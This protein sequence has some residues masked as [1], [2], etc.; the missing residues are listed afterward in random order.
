MSMLVWVG[1]YIEIET[2]AKG[3]SISV[4]EKYTGCPKCKTYKPIGKFC[5]DCG[6]AIEE[7]EKSKKIDDM[8]DLADY[9]YDK[10]KINE[11]D[12]YPD[13]LYTPQYSKNIILSNVNSKT[14]DRDNYNTHLSIPKLAENAGASNK[15]FEFE[16]K[17]FLEC[18]DKEG[19]K[20]K[21]VYGIYID[22]M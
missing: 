8:F 6:H 13:I 2:A 4:V 11:D 20:Y 16:A 15:K 21:I 10:Y 17:T 19:I 12:K 3:K 1:S 5:A 9:I 7:L 14:Y 22:D 18:L